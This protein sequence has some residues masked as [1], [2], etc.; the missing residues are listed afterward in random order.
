MIKKAI[1]ISTLAVLCLVFS[2]Q[3]QEFA[4]VGTAVAQFLEIG[5][6]A[7]ATGMG[8]A[9][10]TVSDDAGSSFWNPAGLVD[11]E[12]RSFFLAYNKW[13]ADI[14]LGAV[15]V[16]WNL[17]NWGVVGVNS[18]FI[19]TDDMAIT[20]IDDPEGLSG[21]TFGISNYTFGLSYARF[22][23]N[24]LS[25]GATLKMVHEKYW[26]YGY[27]TWAVDLGTIYR[28]GFRGLKIGMSILHFG[29][30]IQFDG[31]Y[32]DYSDDKKSKSFE[33]YSLP[34]NFRVGASMNAWESGKNKIVTAFDMVHPNNNLEQYNMGLEYGFDQ[35]IFIRGGYKFQMDEGG[36]TLGAGARYK[37]FGDQFTAVDYSFAEVGVL[38]SIHRLSVSFGF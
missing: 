12:K 3:A 4:P 16:A 38:P 34:I 25:I 31:N 11:L 22:L 5:M 29:Q 30:E 14:S 18:V 32:I 1:Y 2:L 23:T 26:D 7:R 17:G 37:L 6:G 13:P 36:L 24:R 9:F 21:Q 28:T 10:T 15:S 8:E 33:K 35:M 27:D 20:T 19:N